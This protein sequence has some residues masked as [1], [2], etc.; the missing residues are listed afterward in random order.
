M[1]ILAYREL[2]VL[3]LAIGAV[4]L[5]ITKANVFEWLRAWIDRR[6][7]KPRGFLRRPFG[8]LNELF[9]CPY[10]MAHWIALAAMFVYKPLLI[11]TGREWPDLIV[12]YFA[13]VALSSLC[14]G[15]VFRIFGGKA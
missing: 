3:A 10:C 8:W 11:S 6:A 2:G 13:L 15:A 1:E 4:S 14:A 7:R 12:S 9:D 5:T